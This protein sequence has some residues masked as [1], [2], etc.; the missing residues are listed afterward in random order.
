MPRRRRRLNSPAASADPVEPPETSACA[1]PSA[2]ARAA[3]TIEASGVERAASA[4]SA[5]LA[6]DTG[7]STT[8]TPSGTAPISA[9][10]PKRSTRVP[11]SAAIAAP[12]ATSAAPRSAPLASTATVTGSVIPAAPLVVVLV[13]VLVGRDDLAPGVGAAVRA[14][15]VG[16]ARVVAVRALVHRGRAD[17]VL[18]AP[19]AGARTRL[20]LLW[21]GHRR[22]RV[23]TTLRWA[24]RPGHGGYR[25]AVLAPPRSGG[26]VVYEP[27]A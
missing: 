20:L 14:H 6:I 12:A 25:E 27:E 23:P 1:R 17:L 16:T 24:G 22:C 19:L 9:A 4:G 21:D 5:A 8:S 10:G 26:L 11:R 7:A 13:L 18:R 3:W 15:P 2:T